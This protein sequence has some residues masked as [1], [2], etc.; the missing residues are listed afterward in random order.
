MFCTR[1]MTGGHTEGKEESTDAERQSLRIFMKN[2][3]NRKGNHRRAN[4][5]LNFR[6]LI[7]ALS[8]EIIL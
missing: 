5:K 6:I 8:V 7:S 1:D 2:R 4:Q 3:R